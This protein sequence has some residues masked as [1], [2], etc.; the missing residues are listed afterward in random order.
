[1][2]DKTIDKMESKNNRLNDLMLRRE[3]LIALN[4]LNHYT[5]TGNKKID[6]YYSCILYVRQEIAKEEMKTF[7]SREEN[8]RKANKAI[9]GLTEQYLSGKINLI[10]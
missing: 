2:S 9:I 3:K 4:S 8:I 5:E 6:K 7:K 10:D 1:L